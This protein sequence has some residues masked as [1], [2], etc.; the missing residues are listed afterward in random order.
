MN[1]DTKP[2]LFPSLI[3]DVLKHPGQC[4]DNV[5]AHVWKGLRFSGL[6]QRSGFKKRS[7][8]P[9]VD[10]VFLLVMWKWIDV[11]SIA[12]FAK[13]SL[14][15]FSEAKRMSCMNCLSVKMLIGVD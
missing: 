13:Q 5:F 15:V 1:N 11:P 3:D 12:V 14:K 10:S 9:I 2:P 8:V 6:T 4:V 7:G